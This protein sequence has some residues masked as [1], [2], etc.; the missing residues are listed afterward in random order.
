MGEQL[1]VSLACTWESVYMSLLR[2]HIQGYV[3]QE[4]LNLMEIDGCDVLFGIPWFYHVDA[5]VNTKAQNI[6]LTHY[7]KDLVLDV[8]LKAMVPSCRC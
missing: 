8:K 4:D 1:K 7:G 2:R 3:R 6:T 5:K